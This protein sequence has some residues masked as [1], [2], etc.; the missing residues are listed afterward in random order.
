MKKGNDITHAFKWGLIIFG[1]SLI[2]A[3]ITFC[4]M[5][6]FNIND[7][8]TT[9]VIAVIE[10]AVGALTGGFIIPQLKGSREIEKKENEIHIIEFYHSF[11]TYWLET[12]KMFIEHPECRKYFY[13]DISLDDLDK[14][15]D[16]YQLLMAYSEYFDDLFR[17][18][19]AELIKQLREFSV[20]PI[21]QIESYLKYME[22]IMK[23]PVFR[24]YLRE[25]RGN[26]NSNYDNKEINELKEMIHHLGE[27]DTNDKD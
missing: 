17:Y 1:I 21:D 18:S 6:F 15:S 26:V 19:P 2:L 3:A 12:D 22:S 10:G 23:R 4:V 5:H 8:Y 25:C 14:E 7:T 13:S 20:V 9:M 27:K 24:C 11:I 16:K